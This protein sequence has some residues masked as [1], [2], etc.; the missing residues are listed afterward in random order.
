MIVPGP[1]QIFV[2][3]QLDNSP[4]RERN[5]SA[6]DPLDNEEREMIP[7][8]RHGGWRPMPRTE[9]HGAGDDA[10]GGGSSLL[11]VESLPQIRMSF[12]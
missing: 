1:E 6:Q 8:A 4:A 12:Q 3:E 5:R 9:M 2:A 7:M 10:C 11:G